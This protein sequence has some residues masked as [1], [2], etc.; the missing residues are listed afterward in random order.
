MTMSHDK[1]HFGVPQDVHFTF[2][3]HTTYMYNIILQLYSY[4]GQCCLLL[5]SLS[6]VTNYFVDHS[7]SAISDNH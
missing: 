4:Y 7:Q 2:T 6:Y 1:Y 5:L 3:H